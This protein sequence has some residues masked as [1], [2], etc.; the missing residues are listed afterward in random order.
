MSTTANY[1]GRLTTVHMCKMLAEKGCRS[2]IKSH[3]HRYSIFIHQL[4]RWNKCMPSLYLY[5]FAGDLAP[6]SLWKGRSI[7]GLFIRTMLSSSWGLPNRS[8]G[9]LSTGNESKV[10]RDRRMKLTIWA[11]R[12]ISVSS[13]A[14]KTF[15]QIADART[16]SPLNR[17][18]S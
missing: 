3:E 13:F 17:P 16:A 9:K 4:C 15:L 12:R 2:F 10:R 7:M 1:T 11:S 5:F 8:P 6:G 18:S 14:L